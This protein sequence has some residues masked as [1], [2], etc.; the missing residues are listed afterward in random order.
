VNRLLIG[1]CMIG[2]ALYTVHV[3]S[4]SRGGLPGLSPSKSA[5]YSIVEQTKALSE[6]SELQPIAPTAVQ[7]RHAISPDEAPPKI[8]V[9][10]A[11]PPPQTESTQNLRPQPELPELAPSPE[12]GQEPGE[13]LRVTSETSIHSGPSASAQV[14]GTAHAG[15]MLRVKSR[16][17][18]WVQFAD[19]TANKTGWISLAYLRHAEAGMDAPFTV[20]TRPKQPPKVAKLKS[21]KPMRKIRRSFPTYAEIPTGQQFAPPRRRGFGLFWKRRLSVEDFPPPPYR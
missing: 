13:Q 5:Q 19:P 9:N 2:W 15:A 4:N 12:S 17:S 18:G 7:S 21:P 20:P 16:E 1:L 14:I 6:Q 11:V 8:V 3:N 10:A